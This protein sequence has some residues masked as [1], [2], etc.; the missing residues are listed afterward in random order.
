MEGYLPSDH[1]ASAFEVFTSFEPRVACDQLLKHRIQLVL[2]MLI[3]SMKLM[4]DYR[5][6]SVSI[7]EMGDENEISW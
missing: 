1:L 4:N 7:H 3:L 2:C 6:P 5:T